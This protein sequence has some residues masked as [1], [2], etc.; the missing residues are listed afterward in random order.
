MKNIQINKYKGNKKSI[1]NSINNN[2]SFIKTKLYLFCL[3]SFY[4]AIISNESIAI[5][6]FSN[7][8]NHIIQWFQLHSKSSIYK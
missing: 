5:L 7:S 4:D 3:I 1:K 6:K 8:G 2:I